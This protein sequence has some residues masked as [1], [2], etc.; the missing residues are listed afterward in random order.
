MK[1]TYFKHLDGVRA[2][3]ALM[4][5]AYHFFTYIDLETPLQFHL[6]QVSTLG[7]TGVTLFFVLSGFLITRILL[8]TKGSDGFFKN[9]YIRRAF[10]ILPLYYLFLFIF[11]FAY[12]PL[13]HTAEVTPAGQAIYYFYLQ[14]FSQTFHWTVGGPGHYWSLAVE[15]HFYL[16]WPL[17]I[18]FLNRKH[19]RWFIGGILVVAFALRWIMFSHGYDVSM[20]TLTRMDSLAMGALLALM[21]AERGFSPASARKFLILIAAVLVPSLILLPFVSGKAMLSI[22]VVKYLL[23]TT[24]FFGVIGYLVSI[25]QNDDRPSPLYWILKS[26]FLAYTGRISFGLYVYHPFADMLVQHYL[27]TG[28]WRLNGLLFIALSYAI[29]AFSFHFIEMRFLNL[30]KHFAYGGKPKHIPVVAAP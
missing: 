20:F 13:F 19:V 16:F 5:M 26:P 18:H 24:V 7:R 8:A 11:F 30:K 27:N 2:L 6:F 1:L 10:R 12:P 22:Q 17:V 14:N 25:Q 21:E 28:D 4:V 29:A 15:E 9:F 23:T 3:A